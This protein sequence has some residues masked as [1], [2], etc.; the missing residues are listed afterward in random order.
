MA[1]SAA[2]LGLAFGG[3]TVAAVGLDINDL[4]VAYFIARYVFFTTVWL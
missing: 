4:D 1:L 2:W 3:S